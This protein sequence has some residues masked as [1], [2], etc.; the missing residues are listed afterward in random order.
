MEP[1]NRA[2]TFWHIPATFKR[3][4]RLSSVAR[5]ETT[6]AYSYICYHCIITQSLTIPQEDNVHIHVLLATVQKLFS[7]SPLHLHVESTSYEEC[8][9]CRTQSLSC[10]FSFLREDRKFCWEADQ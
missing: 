7:C 9:S 1:F 6:S 3:Y 8:N 10:F 5:D 4:L 2:G